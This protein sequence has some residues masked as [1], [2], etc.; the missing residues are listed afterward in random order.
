[1]DVQYWYLYDNILREFGRKSL[2]TSVVIEPIVRP[3][4]TISCRLKKKNAI[5]M[6][7]KMKYMS[8]NTFF[9]NIFKRKKIILKIGTPD[10][11]PAFEVGLQVVPTTGRTGYVWLQVLLC[12][13]ISVIFIIF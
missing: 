7:S 13:G 2:I 4:V 1:M 8:Q 6:D 12:T 11:Y 3:Y 9:C 10:S 5:K